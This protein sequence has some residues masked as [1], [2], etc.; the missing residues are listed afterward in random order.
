LPSSFIFWK[1]GVSFSRSRIAV[2]GR[3]EFVAVFE[4]WPDDAPPAWREA[5]LAAYHMIDRDSLEAA[6]LLDGLTAECS[7]DP[8][9]RLIAQRI[10]Q[11]PV[12]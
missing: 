11:T 10:R 1:I 4:P 2:P 9:P 8:V 12:L 6:A 7:D 5:Y 3:D